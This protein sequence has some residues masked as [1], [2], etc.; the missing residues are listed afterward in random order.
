MLHK[1]KKLLITG[2]GPFKN[3]L[4]NPSWEAVQKIDP[5]P[6]WEITKLK[7]DV[8]Y[9]KVSNFTYPSDLDMI[10]HVGVGHDG[11]LRLESLANNSPYLNVDIQ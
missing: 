11:P 9:E 3:Y 10:I 8:E 6:G 2:Y 1:K 7:L 5:I 4:V